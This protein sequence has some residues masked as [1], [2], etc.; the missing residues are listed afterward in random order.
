MNLL[1]AILAVCALVALNVFRL[2]S[3]N[4]H[5]KIS[6]PFII[7]LVL[8]VLIIIGFRFLLRKTF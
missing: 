6:I 8:G 4:Q 2:K 1:M 3:K 5:E 7:A